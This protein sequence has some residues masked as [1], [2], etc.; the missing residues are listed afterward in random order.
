MQP[1]KK[2]TR[3]INSNGED[4]YPTVCA[5]QYKLPQRQGDY[6]GAYVLDYYKVEHTKVS[7]PLTPEHTK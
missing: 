3:R 5:T 6:S 4:V 1:K 7:T 2:Y